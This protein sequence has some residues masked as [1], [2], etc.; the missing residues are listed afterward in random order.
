MPT[1]CYIASTAVAAALGAAEVC[2]AL[3]APSRL[4]TAARLLLLCVWVR[5][6]SGAAGSSAGP[7]L[8]CSEAAASAA[9][10]KAEAGGAMCQVA[11]LAPMD[12]RRTWCSAG[13]QLP[14]PELALNL[15]KSRR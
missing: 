2:A 9:P 3:G 7:A 8:R 12:S 15:I 6:W 10:A 14:P 13:V 5:C 11:A 1:S 4:L